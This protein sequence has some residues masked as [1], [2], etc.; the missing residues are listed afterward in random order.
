MKKDKILYLTGASFRTPTAQLV[1]VLKMCAALS[2]YYDV[3]IFAFDKNS[4]HEL[5]SYSLSREPQIITFKR[6]DISVSLQ[7]LYVLITQVARKRYKAVIT[8]NVV[9]AFVCSTLRIK[10]IY[11]THDAFRGILKNI[12]EPTVLRSQS[13]LKFVVISERL[14]LDYQDLFDCQPAV[15][16]DAADLYK[17]PVVIR[18]KVKKIFYIGSLYAGRGLEIIEGLANL[19]RDLEF[20]IYGGH[21]TFSDANIHYHGYVSQINICNAVAEADV[22]LMPYQSKIETANGGIDT[23]RW[24]SP[25]KM[26]EYMSFG[27]PIISSDL[28]VLKE[29]L[30]SET[31]LFADPPSLDSWND[32]LKSLRENASLRQ[33]L[34]ANAKEAHRQNYTWTKRA[35]AFDRFINA[36]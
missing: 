10:F 23:A 17:L 24:M 21:R 15:C 33:S 4:D 12:F 29:V 32:A 36:Q 25:M 28:P 7:L 18:K 16:H 8:R 22:L 20:H 26:F 35:Q 14:A 19:N 34:G 31:A 1:H 9:I 5:S 27:I 13:L 2:T 11:E 30:S 6:K 3:E